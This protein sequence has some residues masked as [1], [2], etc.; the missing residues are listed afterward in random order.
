M[1]RKVTTQ[2][3]E[4]LFFFALIGA[5]TP[6]QPEATPRLRPAQSGHRREGFLDYALGKIN[7][8]GTDY[9]TRMRAERG[10]LVRYTVDDLYFWSNVLSLLLLTG[11]VT[12]I[13]LQWRA[14]DKKELIS[15]SLIAQLW[16]GR[17]SDRIEIERRTEQFNHLVETHNAEIEQRL[18][19]RSS[20]AAGEEQTASELKRTVEGLGRRPLRP[21]T[22]V[23][24]KPE[25][26]TTTA[27]GD[28]HLSSA[29]ASELE[30][31]NLVLERQVE[32]MKSTEANL[33]KRL[34]EMIARL[35]Q[36]RNR[37]QTLKGA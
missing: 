33:R 29:L 26:R 31:R 10:A 35:E 32:A 30:Q 7:P 6:A 17:V 9:G 34:N 1:S 4:I 37:N 36:E 2:C 24:G 12:A 23:A 14:A 8:N 5:V 28:S 3:I 19:A 22:A 15:V 27:V 18:A 25:S 21:A 20:P 11:A 16:N 13:F